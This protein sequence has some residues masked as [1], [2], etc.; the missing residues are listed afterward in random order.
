MKKL[1]VLALVLV[2]LISGC[3]GG[4]NPSEKTQ[5][6]TMSES[7]TEESGNT[8]ETGTATSEE[9]SHEGT[10]SPETLEEIAS[11]L[12]F[13]EVTNG[14]RGLKIWVQGATW[15]SDSG[16]FKAQ[17]QTDGWFYS[18]GLLYALYEL[19]TY[20]E[21]YLESGKIEGVEYPVLRIPFQLR[22]ASYSGLPR[23]IVALDDGG[24]LHLLRYS[25]DYEYWPSEDEPQVTYLTE[26]EKDITWSL[27]AKRL[28]SGAD[29]SEEHVYY[30]AWNNE[31]V[32]IL[33]FTVESL[34]N[35]IEGNDEKPQPKEFSFSNIRDVIIGW[36]GIYVLSD[37]GL[38]VIKMGDSPEVGDTYPV[39]GDM[40]SAQL[41]EKDAVAV[42][43]GSTLHIVWVRDGKITSSKTL[44]LP[45]YERVFIHMPDLDYPEE[46]EISG[47]GGKSLDLYTLSGEKLDKA[48]SAELPMEPTWLVA[49]IDDENGGIKVS[50]WGTDKAFYYLW[51]G[52]EGESTEGTQTESETGGETST[53]T[54]TQAPQGGDLFSAFTVK[55]VDF[56][57]LRG[58]AVEVNGEPTFRNVEPWF[59]GKTTYELS[60]LSWG[61][62]A[63]GNVLYRVDG[64]GLKNKYM[65]G[66]DVTRS[67]YGEAYVLPAKVKD[68]AMGIYGNEVFFASP[69]GKLYLAYDYEIED[70]EEGDAS[71]RVL[72]YTSWVSWDIAA[73]GVT[74]IA[75]GD[76]SYV[77]W[78]GDKLYVFTYSDDDL[79]YADDEGLNPVQPRTFTLPGKITGVF[80]D[81]YGDGLIIRAGDGFYYLDTSGGYGYGQWHLYTLSENLPGEIS[82]NYHEGIVTLLRDGKF[83]WLD[84][85]S[86]YDDNDELVPYID[87]HGGVGVDG[88]VQAF[89][90]MYN[91]YDYQ[92][93]VALPG[94]L[95]IYN[96]TIFWDEPELVLDQAFEV[97]FTADAVYGEDYCYCHINR[98][99]NYFYLWAGNTY[100]ALIGPNNG[101]LD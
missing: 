2:V 32:Y 61:Y 15:V 81:S 13:D 84:L 44:E 12:H 73:D 62:F 91:T 22:D 49:T 72:N 95:R 37:E 79:Y 19:P 69:D 93:V 52:E 71:L 63:V 43:D 29:Y 25:S 8:A 88:N 64:G 101:R 68:V 51:I 86:K 89:S 46:L 90:L 7:P 59:I 57:G 21:D 96:A 82:Y 17:F 18:N 100:Y 39:K 60:D 74:D 41:S 35:L 78:K 98:Y 47:I 94:E 92:L 23:T 14:A 58:V 50:S 16:S 40:M 67:Y 30:V 26:I 55:T 99:D 87:I 1:L 75:S 9:P 11:M 85:G 80:R 36:N 54:E 34:N 6:P 42:Y 65:D 66:E 97:P 24:T 4:S 83:Y 56:G 5:S 3:M 53:E 38:T 33:A 27:N 76:Y 48:F 45:G 31:K 70:E 77:A 20:G 10:S 28:F